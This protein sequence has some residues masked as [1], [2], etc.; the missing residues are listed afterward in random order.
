M[1][2]DDEPELRDA[3]AELHRRQSELAPAFEPMR[4]RAL[5]SAEK[6]DRAKPMLGRLRLP[7]AA[8][9]AMALAATAWWALRTAESVP[10]H[11]AATASTQ[12]AEVLL[13][14]IEQE[15]ER[16]DAYAVPVFPTDVLLTHY[17]S[18]SEL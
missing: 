4:A 1:K 8:A 9:A 10:T 12:R 6:A 17:P 18:Q 13:T 14:R 15:L 5:R 16:R 11:I 7:L 2:P 3:F